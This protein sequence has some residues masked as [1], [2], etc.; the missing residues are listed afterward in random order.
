MKAL[1][2]Y[3][4]YH[5]PGELAKEGLQEIT[6]PEM[7]IEFTDAEDGIPGDFPTNCS[8]LILNKANMTSSD[9]DASWVTKDW[10]IQIRD[11]VENGGTLLAIHSGLAG[12]EKGGI[13]GSLLGGTF[14]W[15]PAMCEVSYRS[16]SDVFSCRDEHYFVEVYDEDAEIILTSESR[17]GRQPAGWIC[18]RGRGRVVVLTPGHTSDVW[19]HSAFRKIV[20]QVLQTK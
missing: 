10:E 19:N 11:F 3:H 5:H 20:L 2:I 9:K 16:D 15:H 17:Y 1:C 8:I 7:S 18:T 12:Y 6:P 4:D 14:K 13:L